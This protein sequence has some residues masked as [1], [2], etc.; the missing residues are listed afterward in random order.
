MFRYRKAIW[1]RVCVVAGS[2]LWEVI[3]IK[4]SQRVGSD[5]ETESVFLSKIVTARL[6]RPIPIMMREVGPIPRNTDYIV[7]VARGRI[8]CA[9][10]NFS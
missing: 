2:V 9:R 8:H 6:I 10:H 1:Y 4:K 3:Q 5:S 7:G